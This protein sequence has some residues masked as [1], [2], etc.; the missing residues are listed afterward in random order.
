MDDPWGFG[1]RGRNG[2]GPYG[3]GRGN[4]SQ[5]FGMNGLQ[6]GGQPPLKAGGFLQKLLSGKRSHLNQS[7]SSDLAGHT[8]Q[9]FNSSIGPTA[10]TGIHELVSPS[11]QA[12]GSKFMGALDKVQGFIKMAESAAPLVEQYGPLVKNIPALISL[13]NNNEDGEANKNDE[14]EKVDAIKESNIETSKKKKAGDKKLKKENYIEKEPVVKKSKK[15]YRKTPIEAKK[16]N[17]EHKVSTP[18]LYV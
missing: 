8:M 18:K 17:K 13:I 4:D 2:L 11:T 9:S 6:Q 1:P 10:Q 5:Q 3:F 7:R 16:M 14:I 12:N 15:Y